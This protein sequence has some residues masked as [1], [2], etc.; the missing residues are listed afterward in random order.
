MRLT[1]SRSSVSSFVGTCRCC[2]SLKRY[3][4]CA[5]DYVC[6]FSAKLSLAIDSVLRPLFSP[7]GKYDGKVKVIFRNQVQPWHA[8]S[9]FVHE[10]GIAVSICPSLYPHFVARPAA[11]RLGRRSTYVQRRS[12]ERIRNVAETLTRWFLHR[13]RG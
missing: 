4:V 7:G 8:S 10:A 13:S 9:T 11:A 3:T 5:V 6:P 12:S 1:R 2:Q